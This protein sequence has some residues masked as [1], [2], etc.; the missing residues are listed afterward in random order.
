[1]LPTIGRRS[2]IPPVAERSVLSWPLWSRTLRGQRRTSRSLANA[3]RSLGTSR[4]DTRA[5][6]I[7]TVG[8]TMRSH[9]L[10]TEASLR[11]GILGS[12]RIEVDGEEVPLPSGK[13]RALLAALLIDVGAV[14]STGRLADVLWG[15]DQPDDPARAIRTHVS[16]LRSVLLEWGGEQA[17]AVLVTRPKGYALAVDPDWVD[18]GR[19]ERL[20]GEAHTA[21][22][23]QVRVHLT[24]EALALCRGVPLFEF[25]HPDA[26][27]ERARLEGLRGEALELR[28]DAM[29]RLGRYSEVVTELP[30][31]VERHPLH[32]KLRGQ[33]MVALY[34]CGRQADALAAY[35]HLRD[36]LVG[37]LGVEP[38]A[39]LRQLET[40]I[41]QQVD[42]LPWPC[43]PVGLNASTGERRGPHQARSSTS[44]LPDEL[45]S[46]VGRE[47][48]VRALEA[49]LRERRIVVLSGVGGVG[50]SRL[51][52]RVAREV[53]DNYADGVVLCDLVSADDDGAVSDV[54][55][56]ALG[57]LP[58]PSGDS[59]DGLLESLR[60]Q[61]V[62]LVLDNCEHVVTGASKLVDRIARRCPGVAVLATTRQPLRTAVQ[63]IWPVMPLEVDG[64]DGAGVEL[65]RDRAASADP[66]F[67]LTDADRDVV[68]E[69]CRRL[70]GLPLAVEL[71]AA[72][73]RFMNPADVVDRLDHRFDMLTSGPSTAPPRHRSL[74]AVLDWSYELLPDRTQ[75]LLDRLAVFAGGSTLDAAVLVCAGEGLPAPDVANRLADLVDQSLVSVDR[76]GRHARYR[77]LETVRAYGEAHLRAGGDLQ[78]W[79]RRHAEHFASLAEEAADGLRGPDEA[80]WVQVLDTELANLRAAQSWAC[81][82]GHVDLALRLASLLHVYAY[83]RLHDEVH[84]W[85]LRAVDLPG[86][87]VHPEYPATLVAAAV[88][89]VQRGELE[90]ARE[91]GEKALAVASQEQVV[92][93][94][95]Q[96]L[97]EI[98]LYQGRLEE[99]DQRGLELAERSRSVGDAYYESLGYL[100]RVH[101]AAYSGRAGEARGH[102]SA[103]WQAVGVAGTPTLR[104]GTSRERFESTTIWRRHARRSSRRSR[105]LGRCAT[106][107]WPG[108]LVSPSP[109]WRRGTGSRTK[110]WPPSARSSTTGARPATGSICGRPSTTWS[111]C[112][113]ASGKP[114]QG[115][116]CTARCTPPPRGG[117][118][119]VRTPSDSGPPLPPSGTLW[120]K[121]HSQPP[122]P[123]VGA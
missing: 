3:L 123:A 113:S 27:T 115:R 47:G 93:R 83:Q 87:S 22:S 25:D 111:S 106:G 62:L 96:L 11:F 78:V 88:G 38:S 55:A 26:N 84:G 94:A 32:E 23:P 28:A 92:L 21:S 98:S 20:V 61:Q 45:T 71:A 24:G 103:G 7:S 99:A 34:R 119:S 89:R 5:C 46:F 91:D 101:A 39:A 10:A 44:V 16:R 69:I 56:T 109:P 37:E 104:A 81:T 79:R 95:Q 13:Q 6:P 64:M 14:V 97:A 42:D 12:L 117:G 85:A 40:A 108:L 54:V 57:A 114:N 72:Q 118:S 80:H 18:A 75:R 48:D 49:A 51:A 66:T 2:G 41:L 58:A 31:L 86:A 4:I 76:S 121:A 67:E 53:A 77:L 74:Q 105:R 43:P 82:T 70:D 116:S 59:G 8:R 122:R 50:K 36:A 102:L 15:D 90:R 65:F 112:S 68:V 17:T 107:S 100:Y 29:L 63:Q 1:M 35:R 110:P 19:F 30:A 60:A 52:L 73:V 120:G 33:L 9:S